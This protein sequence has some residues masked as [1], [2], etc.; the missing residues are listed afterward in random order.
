LL[1]QPECHIFSRNV[2]AIVSIRFHPAF[3]FREPAGPCRPRFSFFSIQLSKNRHRHTVSRVVWHFCLWTP[4]SV[5]Y[6]ALFEMLQERTFWSPAARRPRC[7]GYIVG[8]SSW[9]QQ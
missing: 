4:S 9:C 6:A 3:A 7:D 8:D 1:S 5:A 2:S